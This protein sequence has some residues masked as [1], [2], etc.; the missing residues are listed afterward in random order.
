AGNKR[1][2]FNNVGK[3]T[4]PYYGSGTHTGTAA[5]NLQVDASGN[6]IET[7]AGGTTPTM[8]QVFDKETG[9]AL[10]N[11]D[12][13]INA[14]GHDFY[15]IGGRNYS[16]QIDNGTNLMQVGTTFYTR[17]YQSINGSERPYT[18]IEA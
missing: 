17:I 18:G 8:Q 9:E 12:D 5:Y 6:V 3:A 4:L 10:L 1:L 13:T 11:K 15:E 14:N 2:Q 7:T 16:R